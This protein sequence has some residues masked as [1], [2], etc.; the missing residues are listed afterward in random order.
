MSKLKVALGL[1]SVSI[2]FS[3]AVIFKKTYVY[4]IKAW[5]DLL[6]NFTI[7]LFICTNELLVH[8]NLES[9]YLILH[10]GNEN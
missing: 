8:P 5:N 10:P 4:C 1:T 3:K 2:N 9:N 6:Q 7:A